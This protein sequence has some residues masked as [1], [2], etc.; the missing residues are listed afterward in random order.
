[1]YTPVGGLNENDIGAF[2]IK[3]GAI[4]VLVLLI[5]LKTEI[6]LKLGFL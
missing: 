6:F 2:N 3:G 5:Q 4:F 1:M